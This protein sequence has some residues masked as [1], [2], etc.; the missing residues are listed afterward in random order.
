MEFPT[1]SMAHM[2]SGS[3]REFLLPVEL[4]ERLF[5]GPCERSTQIWWYDTPVN[6]NAGNKVEDEN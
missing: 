3:C 5:P 4:S 1:T 6:D 2:S